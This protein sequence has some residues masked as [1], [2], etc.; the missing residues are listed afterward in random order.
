MSKR[1]DLRKERLNGLVGTTQHFVGKIARGTTYEVDGV[2]KVLISP[3]YVEIDGAYSYIE[4]SWM[5][6][7]EDYALKIGYTIDFQGEVYSYKKESSVK[8]FG[9]NFVSAEN[10]EKTELYDE[11]KMNF[12]ESKDIDKKVRRYVNNNLSVI[13]AFEN[14]EDLRVPRKGYEKAFARKIKSGQQLGKRAEDP[15]LWNTLAWN[16]LQ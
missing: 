16:V 2:S 4:H 8:G 3:L 14:G 11:L 15:M 7:P 6:L 5:I 10:L 1:F 13:V 9:I 12:V